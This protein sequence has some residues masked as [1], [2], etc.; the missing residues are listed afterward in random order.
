MRRGLGFLVAAGVLS[1]AAGGCSLMEYCPMHMAMRAMTKKSAP[2]AEAA[3]PDAATTQTTCPVLG[4]KIDRQVYT[5]YNGMRVYFCCPG[6]IGTFQK[7]PEKYLATL[8]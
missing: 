1:L 6:C 5:D 2:P 7:D 4:G 3:A 8:K